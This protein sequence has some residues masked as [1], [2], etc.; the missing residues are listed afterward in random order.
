MQKTTR[1]KNKGVNNIFLRTPELDRLCGT[2]NFFLI[3]EKGTGKTAY[4]AYMSNCEYKNNFARLRYLRAT[5]VLKFV[6]LKKS[7]HLELSDYTSIWKVIIYV[8]IA[9]RIREGNPFVNQAFPTFDRLGKAI[10][11][12]YNHAFSP[13][14]INAISFAEESSISASLLFKMGQVAGKEKNIV[15][16]TEDNFQVNLLYIQKQF[17]DAFS[18]IKLKNNQLLFIDGI[19]I[20]PE[21]V[22]YDTYIESIKGLANAVWAVNNDFF[23]NIKDSKGR[24]RVVLLVRP[25][26]N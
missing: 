26:Y 11:A 20:R 8:L 13:G 16:F 15:N 1:G 2:H 9:Q 7:K 12:F 4:A 10:D 5:E 23:S 14:I 6:S 18:S 21:S 17:E 19:D 25:R 22:D 3:G 24:I